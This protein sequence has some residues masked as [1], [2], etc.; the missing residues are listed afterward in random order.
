VDPIPW[1][2]E[3]DPAIRYQAMR[4]LV[5]SSPSSLAEERSRTVR[6]GLGAKILAAQ[7]PDG[8]WHLEGKP[9]WLP[10]LLSMQLLR[11]SS[12]DAEEPP[13]KAAMTRLENGFRWHESLG[14]KP[15][16]EGETEPCINGNAL[17]ASAS[18]GRASDALALRL[19]AE[20][21][22][23]GG[24]NCE[25]PK[26]LRSSFHSTICVLEGLFEHERARGASREITAA[27]KRGE[28]YLLD[29]NLFRRRSTGEV[30]SAG[31]LE[32][33]FPPRYGYDVLRGLDYFREALETPD[34]R[35]NEAVTHLVR[36]RRADG[37]WILDRTHDEALPFAF[38]EA[39]G[40]PSRW[41]TLRALRVLRWW[42]R[43]PRET[44]R[45]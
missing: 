33:A 24:W 44:G 21:L 27:R 1:L 5:G 35:M 42:A 18:L 20:Q 6:E 12:V 11:A 45:H 23:D 19:V 39:A 26:S 13:V 38:P 4:D 2:L 29:R 17:A 8:A 9:D 36:K 32:F 40:E 37:C 28:A 25:A 41:N 22:E 30:A 7:G 15:F 3:G 43:G 16:F 34:P 10:T 31:F 14:G